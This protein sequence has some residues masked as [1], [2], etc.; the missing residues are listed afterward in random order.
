MI[1]A[2]S[3]VAILLSLGAGTSA[4]APTARVK[5]VIDYGDG[6]QKV[7]AGLSWKEGMTV[8][9]T[10]KSAQRAPHGISFD[11]QGEGAT[12]FVTQIDDLRNQGGGKEAKNWQYRVNGTFVKE[13][14]GTR[15]LQ[16]GDEVLWIFDH[17]PPRAGH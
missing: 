17:F 11:H 6:T 8:L 4:D 15:G 5:L 7:F 14:S 12:A 2:L 3:I 10:L 13:S 1:Q 9:D 16:P